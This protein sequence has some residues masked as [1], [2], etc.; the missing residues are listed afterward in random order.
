MHMAKV[1]VKLLNGDY[2][3]EGG[4]IADLRLMVE[5]CR[6]YEPSLVQ[7]IRTLSVVGGTEVCPSSFRH[8]VPSFGDDQTSFPMRASPPKMLTMQVR[9][10]PSVISFSVLERKEESSVVVVVSLP[11]LSSTLT[12]KPVGA[13][14]TSCTRGMHAPCPVKWHAHAH[15]H[16]G[17][18][19][20][21]VSTIRIPPRRRL[22]TRRR[23]TMPWKR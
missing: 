19:P 5:N 9:S 17:T 15:A 12:A 6:R 22:P 3:D 4:M 23:S 14:I 18:T 8:P 7:P 13:H 2:A 10:D 20:A 11:P 21:T 1:V 16:A